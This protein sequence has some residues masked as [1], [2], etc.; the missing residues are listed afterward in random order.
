M[1]ILKVIDGNIDLIDTIVNKNCKQKCFFSNQDN[2]YHQKKINLSNCTIASIPPTTKLEKNENKKSESD[3]DDY[4]LNNVSTSE[5]YIFTKLPTYFSNKKLNRKNIVLKMSYDDRIQ[6]NQ[7]KK[8]YYFEN[9]D[10]DDEEINIPE[11]LIPYWDNRAIVNCQPK[12]NSSSDFVQIKSPKQFHW[13]PNE[14]SLRKNNEGTNKMNVLIY[15]SPSVNKHFKIS[16]NKVSV[17][18]GDMKNL[19]MGN[20]D[21]LYENKHL[22][23]VIDKDIAHNIQMNV[24]DLSKDNFSNDE[25]PKKQLK[26]KRSI[27]KGDLIACYENFKDDYQFHEKFNSIKKPFEYDPITDTKYSNMN[28]LKDKIYHYNQRI[29]D[30]Q[31]NSSAPP[32]AFDHIHTYNSRELQRKMFH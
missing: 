6:K 28:H 32:R 10:I 3:S 1:R 7:K 8:K 25:L 24:D 27:P 14:K 23:V 30:H 19:N 16:S 22:K 4:D 26:K 13:K 11:E 12:A 21:V 29:E 15:T 9:K 5:K 31:N 17:S 18:K 2:I 20:K